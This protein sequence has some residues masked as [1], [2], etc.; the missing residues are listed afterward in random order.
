MITEDV[1]AGVPPP[2][3]EGGPFAQDINT[4]R[5][6][7]NTSKAKA[8]RHAGCRG[9]NSARPKIP[10]IQIASVPSI[11]PNIG[12]RAAPIAFTAAVRAVVEIVTCV[13]AACVPS[14]VIDI[15]TNAQA[16]ALGR[17]LQLKLTVCV[18]PFCGVTVNATVPDCPATIVRLPGLAETLKSAAAF[19]VCVT[20]GDV[21][22]A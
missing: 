15:G 19:T 4:A 13:I 1:P 14:S 8:T 22:V 7:V 3:E 2:P 16:D 11:C 18:E 6:I 17:P 21:L 12:G 10:A 9:R 20:T 5:G